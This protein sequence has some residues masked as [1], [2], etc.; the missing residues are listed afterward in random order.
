MLFSNQATIWW[1]S[2]PQAKTADGSNSIAT[3]AKTDF[4]AAK[5][6]LGASSKVGHLQLGRNRS[7]DIISIFIRW[8]C[9]G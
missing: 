8:E 5:L 2:P 7:R 9:R 4:T 6:T 1:P 3:N